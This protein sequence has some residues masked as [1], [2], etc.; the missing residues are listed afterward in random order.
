MARIIKEICKIRDI[1]ISG[2]DKKISN[3]RYADASGLYERTSWR[4]RDVIKKKTQEPDYEL[5]ITSQDLRE[6]AAD[7][8]AVFKRWEK[9]LDA[10]TNT[11]WLLTCIDESRNLDLNPYINK[12]LPTMIARVNTSRYLVGLLNMAEYMAV[13]LYM[14]ELANVD[15]FALK[16]TERFENNT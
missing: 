3:P 14:I 13:F 2:D 4:L 11:K 16:F 6:L 9:T 1:L 8:K 7:I 5:D 10:E 15:E 12:A